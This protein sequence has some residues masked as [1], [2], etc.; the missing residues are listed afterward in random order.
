MPSDTRALVIEIMLHEDRWHGDGDWPPSPFRLFQALVAAAARGTRLQEADRQAL[1]WLEALEPP[2]IAAPCNV[3][4][5]RTMFA[6]VPDN[7]LDGKDAKGNPDRIEQIRSP[8]RTTPHLLDGA[9]RFLYV[10]HFEAQQ[11][12]VRNHMDRVQQI[13]HQLYQ[14]GRGIDMAWARAH[15]LAPEEAKTMLRGHPGGM[16]DPCDGGD[17]RLPVPTPGSLHS[18]EQRFAQFRQ[19]LQ[20]VQKGRTVRVHFRQPS[21]PVRRMVGYACPP[22]RLLFDIRKVGQPERFAPDTQRRVAP[23]VAQLRDLAAARL[24]AAGVEKARIERYLVGRGA[25]AQ[26][27]KRRARILPLPSIGHEFA[28]GGIRRVL[29]EVPQE[30][31]LDKED[32]RWAFEGLSWDE[33]VDFETGELTAGHMLVETT[34]TR[35][36]NNYGVERKN[37]AIHWRTITPAAL[38]ARRRGKTGSERLSTEEHVIRAVRT[39]L[40]HAGVRARPLRID[41]QREPFDRNSH[42]AGDYEP[43]RFDARQ[44]WHVEIVLEEPVSGPLL[45]GNGRYLGLGLMAPVPRSERVGGHLRE[46]FTFELAGPPLAWEAAPRLLALVRAALMRM[47]AE[48][49]GGKSCRLFSGH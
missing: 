8:K 46:V 6:F 20:I 36:L 41:V 40:R 25:D 38:P 43:D 4:T 49:H 24:R 16:H 44:L 5:G 3:G 30:S 29:V 13:V 11:D 12:A 39:A 28:G 2:A 9:P 15:V 18:L 17:R 37:G 48:Q 33:N 22:H 32:V 42:M 26:D 34:D 47:D 1:K 31:P 7:D 19:R 10:W 35:M 45:I 21:K 27:K 14:F 23:L